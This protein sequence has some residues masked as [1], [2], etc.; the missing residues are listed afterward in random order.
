MEIFKFKFEGP[1]SNKNK[2]EISP[3][4]LQGRARVIKIFF[5]NFYNLYENFSISVSLKIKKIKCSH[6]HPL[7]AHLTIFFFLI[8]LN[9]ME[10]LVFMVD[11]L[12]YNNKE[13]KRER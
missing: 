8:S 12:I 13:N 1:I 6:P 7:G 11:G 9:N 3:L 2:I 5:L 10:I 4:P